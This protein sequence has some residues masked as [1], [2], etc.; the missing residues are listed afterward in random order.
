MGQAADI[1]KRDVGKRDVT[2]FDTQRLNM[3]ES[4]VRPSDVTDRH[5][6]R[7]MSA[8]PRELFV[9]PASRSIAYADED[10]RVTPGSAG[11]APRALLAPRVLAKLIQAAEIVD[12][13]RVLDIGCA[14]GYSTALL[15]RLA[16]EVIGLEADETLAASA[17]AALVTLSISSAR[18][19]HGPLNKGWPAAAPYDVILLNGAVPAVP[20]A[21]LQQLA[22]GGRLV[23]I[24]TDKGMLGSVKVHVK[25][26]AATSVRAAFDAGAHILPGFDISTGFR[27]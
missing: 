18:I 24:V 23:A 3:V 2:D 17:R 25:R 10:I 8:V 26:G 5:L 4:Q 21:L 9:P 6:M 13:D 20:A 14:T 15:S 11:A 22:E 1:G 7:A 12:T 27:F 19:E 16:A